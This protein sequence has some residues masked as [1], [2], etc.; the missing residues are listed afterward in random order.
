MGPVAMYTVGGASIGFQAG[1]DQTDFVMLVM[2]ETGIKHLYGEKTSG[3]EILMDSKL[4]VPAAAKAA[5]D[6]I[7]RH[8]GAAVAKEAQ[9]EAKE[10][11]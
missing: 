8:M 2:N 3:A 7:R 11:K 6:S 5:M 10:R 1:V 9:E 4:G